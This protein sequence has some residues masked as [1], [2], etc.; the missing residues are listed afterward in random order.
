MWS[1]W[2]EDTIYHI[3]YMYDIQGKTEQQEKLKRICMNELNNHPK[4]KENI[5]TGKQLQDFIIQM[6]MESIR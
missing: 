2:V 3:F 5:Y 4:I 1:K 6:A